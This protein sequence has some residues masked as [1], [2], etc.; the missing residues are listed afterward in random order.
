[1]HAIRRSFQDK[2]LRRRAAAR[3]IDSATVGMLSLS[4]AWLLRR[5]GFRAMTITRRSREGSREPGLAVALTALLNVLWCVTFEAKAGWTPGKRVAGLRV[6]SLDGSRA[7]V[8]AIALRNLL[9][10]F[11]GWWLGML[12]IPF[13]RRGRSLMDLV[14]GTAVVP[15]D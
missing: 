3:L 13:D 1:M 8:R 4:L 9:L 15:S 12:V 7:P 11:P 2:L 14:A 10:P 6:A 5:A